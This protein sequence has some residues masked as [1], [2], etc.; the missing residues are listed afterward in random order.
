MAKQ[1]GAIQAL[2]K[3]VSLKQSLEKRTPGNFVPK[4]PAYMIKFQNWSFK[5]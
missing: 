1:K 2:L 4:F 3:V 5:L